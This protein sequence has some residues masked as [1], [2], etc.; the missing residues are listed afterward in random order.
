ME[1]T[2]KRVRILKRRSTNIE[3]PKTQNIIT[4]FA[5]KAFR[6]TETQIKSIKNDLLLPKG[7][8][9]G[10]LTKLFK[11]KFYMEPNKTI[12][13]KGILV[14]MGKGKGKIKSTGLFLTPKQI[15]VILIPLTFGSDPE[16]LTNRNASDNY[17]FKVLDKFVSKY[18]FL[19]Y[20]KSL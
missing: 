16:G 12:T 8:T 1:L 7:L 17:I 5:N 20:K 4:I 9:L 3:V 2:Q 15:C 19:S 11:I 14:R 13:Q 6:L 18:T 10:R